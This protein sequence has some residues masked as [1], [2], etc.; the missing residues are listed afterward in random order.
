VSGRV[1]GRLCMKV[2]SLALHH[3]RRHSSHSAH[4]AHDNRK[5]RI[6]NLSRSVAIY[7]NAIEFHMNKTSRVCASCAA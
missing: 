5:R 6:E 1:S 2:M 3:E 7:R 4:A